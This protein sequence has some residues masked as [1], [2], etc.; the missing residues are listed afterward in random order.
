MDIRVR[1]DAVRSGGRG[2]RRCA[3]GQQGMNWCA[4]DE[5]TDW[6]GRWRRMCSVDLEA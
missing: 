6:E 2:P 3:G 5:S 1:G 4:E